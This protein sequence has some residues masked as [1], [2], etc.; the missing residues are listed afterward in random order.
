M[1]RQ[2]L[3]SKRVRTRSLGRF[4]NRYQRVARYG[5]DLV[6]WSRLLSSRRD[7]IPLDLSPALLTTKGLTEQPPALFISEADHHL[8]HWEDGFRAVNAALFLNLQR[9][10]L[11]SKYRYIHPAPSFQGIYLWDTAFTAQAWKHWDHQVAYEV[12]RA[13]IELRDGKRLQ[14]VVTSFQQSEYTQPPV[15]AWSCQQLL[16]W[17][18]SFSQEDFETEIYRPLIEYNEWLYQF[19]KLENGLFFW[20]HPYESGIDNSPRF[21]T[22]DESVFA[23]TKVLASP[24]LSSYVVL[25]NEAI[26][27]MAERLEDRENAEKFR[28]QAEELRELIN[29][30]LWDENDAFYYDLNVETNQFVRSETIAG[31]IPLWAGVPTTDQAEGLR[32]HIVDHDEFNTP[33]PLPSVALSDPEFAKDMWRGPVWINMAYGVILGM[34]RYKMHDELADFG[35]RLCDGVYRTYAHVRRLL[36]FYDPERFDIEQLE[37]KKGNWFKHLTLGS[38]PVKEF[39]GWTGLV[40]TLVIEQLIGLNCRRGHLRLSPGFPARARGTG[41][42]IR[43]PRERRAV[44]VDVM[45][46]GSYRC[47]VRQN[48][49]VD[50]FELKDGETIDLGPTLSRSGRIA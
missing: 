5:L 41:F 39:V 28:I 23:N 24:D 34:Q 2:I 32:Q 35:F 37:R 46:D 33:I 50:T 44:S 27:T 40:N 9:P 4:A 22:R 21:S 7:P 16:D 3:A 36:E 45:N 14:H 13:V 43:L 11:L 49:T 48:G 1:L 6:L 8:A 10:D 29:Q 19:R 47:A 42:A 26:A 30:Y 20:A 17:R 18:E 38:K 25:Q 15:M 31:L 12:N